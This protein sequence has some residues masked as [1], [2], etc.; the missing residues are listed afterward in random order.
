MSRMLEQKRAVYTM[1]FVTGY[2]GDKTTL[3]THIQKTPIR[4]LQNGL[5]QAL[6]FL[7][8]DDEN[9]HKEP[10]YKVYLHLQEWF[11]GPDSPDH[12]CRVYNV[13]QCNLIKQLIEGDRRE[14]LQAQEEA[15]RLFTWLKKFADAYLD[16]P[17][18]GGQSDA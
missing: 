18:R 13:Q 9:K 6:A 16:V 1:Q 14:Y 12:P 3:A 8:A 7:L 10:S 5:G 17:A 2:T 4:I 11:C 15:I